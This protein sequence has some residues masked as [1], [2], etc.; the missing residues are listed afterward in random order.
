MFISQKLGHNKPSR[1]Y[2]EACYALIPDFDASK[3]LMVGDSLSSDI[4]GGINGGMK[5]C[6]VNPQHK[7][8]GDIVPDYEIENIN[9]LE[10]L[11]ETL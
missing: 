6:W 8:A 11:L 9:Q 10:A 2:F 5:T 3:A 4:L 1:E 7:K